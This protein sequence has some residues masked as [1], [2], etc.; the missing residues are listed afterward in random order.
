MNRAPGHLPISE[1]LA[2]K[3]IVEPRDLLPSAEES[4]GREDKPARISKTWREVRAYTL[5]LGYVRKYQFLVHHLPSYS[6]PLKQIVES[7]QTL[8]WS[9]E[10]VRSW[11]EMVEDILAQAFAL[12]DG[13]DYMTALDRLSD[14]RASLEGNNGM[15]PGAT[16][17]LYT[18]LLFRLGW[19]HPK[20]TNWGARY[21]YVDKGGLAFRFLEIDVTGFPLDYNPEDYWQE[22]SCRRF[23]YG[24]V[25][26]GN[27]VPLPE[28]TFNALPTVDDPAHYKTQSAH[29]LEEALAS[30]R[31]AIPIGAIVQQ[32]LGPLKWF[33]I[34]EEGNNICFVG[35]DSK[36]RFLLAYFFRRDDGSWQFICDSLEPDKQLPKPMTEEI[37][38]FQYL[39]SLIVRDFWVLE[40][41][42]LRRVFANGNP[43]RV[44]GIRISRQPDESSRIVYLPRIIYNGTIPRDAAKQVEESLQLKSRAFHSVRE[45]LRQSPSCTERARLLAESY[46]LTVAA[47]YTFVKPH[48]RGDESRQTIYRSRS[49]LACVYR[50][51]P[52][53]RTD[54]GLRGLEFQARVRDGLATRGYQ[55]LG[56]NNCL[57]GPDGGVDIHA[58][59]DTTRFAFQVKEKRPGKRVE[60]DEIRIF[61]DSIRDLPDDTVAIFVTN[62]G[63]T[64]P[65]AALAQTRGIILLGS[66]EVERLLKA[67]H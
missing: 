44:P 65:A 63:Y 11:V 37:A 28:Q 45:H 3:L 48:T 4:I 20:R 17:G 50:L 47:G 15:I 5:S 67:S 6:A 46:G 49:A 2:W 52:E 34:H 18:F 35:R 41:R 54:L 19:Y 57:G 39:L 32:P 30:K 56:M 51:R 13:A 38:A 64:K 23:W 21:P 66:H 53:L 26:E 14:L 25:I 31:R 10:L 8:G 61:A 24:D 60:L 16:T 43:K 62:E 22:L 33:E 36:G 12:F 29:L 9:V 55:I 7:G 40:E 27:D 58:F 42:E 59:L 1:P